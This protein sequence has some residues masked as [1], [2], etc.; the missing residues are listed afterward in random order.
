MKKFITLKPIIIIILYII[1]YIF[2]FIALY[3]IGLIDKESKI[4]F[5]SF[6]SGLGGL[7][8]IIG[9]Y[10]FYQ[11][12]EKQQK[13]I[14]IQINQ[15]VDD[16]FN[17][18]INLLGSSETSARTGA[19]YA[20]YELAIEEEKYR[21]QITQILCSHIRSKTNEAEYKKTHSKRPSNEIQTTID[22]L[23]K[24][25][26]LYAQGFKG[27]AKPS[28]ANLSHAY[29]MGAD[30]RDAQCQGVDFK[31]A[32]CQKAVFR[33]V[34]CQKAD[35]GDARCQGAVF[36][37]AK[38]QKA[39]FMGARCRGADFRDVWCQEADFRNARCQKAD[40]AGARCRGADFMGAQCQEAN[41]M[42]AQCQ[43]ANFMGAECHGAVFAA[44]KCQKADFGDARCQVADFTNAQCQEA[45]FVGAECRGA[46]FEGAKFDRPHDIQIKGESVTKQS[47]PL[48][49]PDLT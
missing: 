37:G 18:A 11:R 23:F 7:I 36:F 20:L 10:F 13:Q 15:R 32:Q 47:K 35:F 21:S 25:E 46:V 38:C 19:I 22:L 14:D 2:I 31:Y 17:S 39:N 40:F 3:F 48:K 12:L 44:T 4:T 43:E 9:L 1:P 24:E 28:K 41:F 8:V 42:N 30:F 27:V 29:L 34:Q 45:N 6:G 5:T 33:D 16:R 49:T 26:G